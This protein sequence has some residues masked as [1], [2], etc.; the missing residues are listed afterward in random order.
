MIFLDSLLMYADDRKIARNIRMTPLKLNKL[1]FWNPKEV[2]HT[3]TCHN[4]FVSKKWM[5]EQSEDVFCIY[6]LI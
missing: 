6:S 4:K 2:L 5:H 1:V 3:T